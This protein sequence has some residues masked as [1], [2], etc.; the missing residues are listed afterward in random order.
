MRILRSLSWGHD[1]TAF[2]LYIFLL[3]TVFVVC[4]FAVGIFV[5]VFYCFLKR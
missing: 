2:F 5:C 3:L 4:R 1:A